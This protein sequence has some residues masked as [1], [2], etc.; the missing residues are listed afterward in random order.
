MPEVACV[1]LGL[2]P[3]DKLRVEAEVVPDAVLPTVVR[4]REE[5]EIGAGKTRSLDDLN[6]SKRQKIYMLYFL[7]D[8]FHF[9]RLIQAYYRN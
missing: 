1:L 3:L 9:W 6:D 5:R 7:W 4:G 2:H 8:C